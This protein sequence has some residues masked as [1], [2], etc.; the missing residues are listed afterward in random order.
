MEDGL[1]LAR[2]FPSVASLTRD[3]WQALL[4]E[5]LDP[6]QHADQV[7][8]Y[9]AVVHNLPSVRAMYE[10]HEALLRRVE[11]AA[12]VN[13]AQR[14]ALEELRAKTR[15]A[16]AQARMLEQQWPCVE[17]SMI[18]AHKQ[19]F[20]P[21][22]LWTR[23]HMAASAV[24]ETSEDLANAYVEGLSPTMD[25]ATFL[26][27]YRELRV[28]YH[29][30]ALAAERMR[31]PSGEERCRAAAVVL[32]RPMSTQP[33]LQRTAGKRIALPVRVEPKVFFA[34][35]RTFLSWLSFTVTLSA[36]AAGLLNFGDRVGR[37][38]AALFSLVAIAIMIYALV[39]YHWRAQAI[40]N[41]GS[42]PYDDRLGPTILSVL[43]LT[44]IIVNFVLR[45]SE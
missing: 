26:R 42:G 21:Q 43:L 24:H 33:L 12:A 4:A 36:L 38:S 37:V 34:N 18:E 32:L 14:P 40:R 1:E 39:T 29:R 11:Q 2:N 23:L 9:E 13:E 27:Q 41:R 25:D 30:R 35:E 7:R 8:L 19:R 22:A 28:Q 5:S 44:A 20:T 3:D 16:Y 31:D 17:Q 45:F 6:T 10:E 15:A